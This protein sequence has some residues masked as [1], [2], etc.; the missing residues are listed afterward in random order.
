MAEGEET[1]PRKKDRWEI[2]QVLLEP[3]GG[4]LTAISVALLGYFGSRTV[5]RQ[6]DYDSNFRLYSE[7]MNQREQ[8]ESALRK[9]MFKSIID[10]FLQPGAKNTL[11]GQLLN[12]EMLAYNFHE[13]L[14]LKPLFVHLDNAIRA[15][16]D[17]KERDADLTRLERVAHEVTRKQVLSLEDTGDK[18]DRRIDLDTLKA[19]P[20]GIMLD[21]D[22]MQVEGIQ[23]SYRVIATDADQKS[24]YVKVRLEVRTLTDSLQS[25]QPSIAEFWVGFYDFPMIDNTRLTHDQR[26]AVVLTDLDERSANISILAFPGSRASL[27]E[28]PYYDEIIDKLRQGNRKLE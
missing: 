23:R 19:N 15:L 2:A 17:P 18:F 13:S 8:S 5:Q 16:K 11:D 1:K 14:D 26:C 22:T 21:E 6:Q 3:V 25:E 9:D 12:I 24:R 7:L 27:R 28:K 20:G 4:L 10:S